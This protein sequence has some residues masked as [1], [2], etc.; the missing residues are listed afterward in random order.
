MTTSSHLR[1]EIREDLQQLHTA[2]AASAD[3]LSVA[4]AT[5]PELFNDPT[6]SHTHSYAA[7]GDQRNH[8]LAAADRL[9]QELWM[10]H[11]GAVLFPG[12]VPQTAA[13]FARQTGGTPK[14]REH[15]I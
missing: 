4:R 11:P 13:S 14:K 5:H 8:P 1:S 3:T 7:H 10:M 6:H 2:V 12:M 15:L 9:S